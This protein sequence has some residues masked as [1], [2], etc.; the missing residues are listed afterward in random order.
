[1]S[2]TLV[3][4]PHEDPVG[5]HD[6]RWIRRLRACGFRVIPIEPVADLG[7]CASLY[8]EDVRD[9]VVL[10]GHLE[11]ALDF[12]EAGF[13]FVVGLSWGFDLWDPDWRSRLS[14]R[15]EAFSSMRALVVDNAASVEHLRD[16]APSVPIH[17][18]PWGVN[19]T[20]FRPARDHLTRLVE[21]PFIVSLRAHDDTH[22]VT[23]IVEAFC[24]A[25][26]SNR[27][28]H[29]GIA[30]SGP[31]TAKYMTRIDEA[32]HSGRVTWFGDLSTIQVAQLLRHADLF[33]AASKVD[34]SSVSLMEALSSDVRCV[35]PDT[36]SNRWWLPSQ[37]YGD[38]Y[39]LGDLVRLSTHMKDATKAVGVEDGVRRQLVLER[40]SL[41]TC[42]AKMEEVLQWAS[43]Q[44][45]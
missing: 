43:P 44:V 42:M 2:P 9:S 7:G 36:P 13:G 35:V 4:Y 15:R 11:R 18:I 40:A 37:Q 20:L 5:V 27:R 32:G 1:M 39:D 31:Q 22:G 16:L 26:E 45:P 21:G 29:L 8:G 10:A 3:L 38:T 23:D 34:G 28:V 24:M 17:V 33:V 19:T 41:K 12:V 14:Q 6:R 30:A 25:A